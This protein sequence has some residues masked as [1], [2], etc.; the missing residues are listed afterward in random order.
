MWEILIAKAHAYILLVDAHRP[1]HFRHGRRILN[2]INQRV[3]IPY[4][5]GLTH[6]DCLG[7]WDMED[8]AI[9]LGLVNQLSRPQI[10]TVNATDRTSVLAALIELIQEAAN[11]YQNA[12]K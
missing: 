3:Q 7:A 2:F 1:E 6:T 9:A 10:I 11:Y 12:T 8:V 5:I 4:L